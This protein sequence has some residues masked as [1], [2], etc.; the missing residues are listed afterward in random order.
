[1]LIALDINGNRIQAYKG[2]L[3]KCQVCKNEV[4]AYCGE[5]NIHHWRHIDLA[6]CDFWKENET[7]WHRKW[8]KKFPIEWQEVIVSDGEQI[9]RAD[10]KTTSGLV[11]EFQNSSISS[12]DV[13]KRERFYSNMI[14]LIN[15]EGFKENFEIWSVVTAQLSYLDKTNPTFN[16]DSIF[17]KDSVN[18][19]ALKNDITTI[20]REINSNGYKIRK[21]TDNIDEIIKLESDLNQ[22]V[23]QFLEGTL[24]YYNPLKSFKS[25]IREGLPL[26]SKTLEEYTET[27]KLKKSHLEKIETFEKCKIPSL[28]NFTIVD[29]KLISSKHYKICK[30]IKKESMNSFFP[31]IINFSSAQDFDRMSRNQNYILVIDFTTIIETLNTEIVKLEGNI[32]KVKN[33]QFKQKDT[34]KIDIESFLRTEKMNGKATIVKLKDKN[35]ELQNELKVQEE[36]LQE[37]IRQEQL[38]EI[39]ANERAEKAIKKR[40][41]DIMKDYKGVYGYHWKY[42]RKTW[43]FAKKPLYLDFGN[44]I[45]HLQNSNTFIKISHQDFVKKIFGYTGLS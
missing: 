25:A 21:L 28:E 16:L 7:E 22:T 35:L 2:G 11:V 38:E 40:R 20:E 30:L 45:F 37:T 13:K 23:D 3:G 42:K 14:W 26:L 19:S 18:V 27:I 39:K 12:T 8:K 32:L 44:S 33:N 29:Y 31:D 24:G 36:Q 17:S 10:I 5:I 41:Y 9:H 6:K 1:M 43:D 34:L 4:R 15:A